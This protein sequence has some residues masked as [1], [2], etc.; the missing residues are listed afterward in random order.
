MTIVKI[1]K[2]NNKG[3][4]ISEDHSMLV[5][6]ALP[7]EI[8][9]VYE[10]KRKKGKKICVAERIIKNS[11]NRTNP[12]EPDHFLSCS[13]LQVFNFALEKKFKKEK[14]FSLL[15]NSNLDFEKKLIRFA[16]NK[17][18]LYNYRN[19][20]EFS[21]YADEED[22]LSLAFFV[23]GS[24]KGKIQ[25]QGCELAYPAINKVANEVLSILNK[26]KIKGRSLKS[27]IVRSNKNGD[28]VASLYVKDEDF[29][30]LKEFKEK[31]NFSF[32]IL[33]SNPLSPSSINSKL[34]FKNG[35]D[36]LFE[37]ISGKIF[38]FGSESFFQINIEMFEKVINDI[39]KHIKKGNLVDLYAGVGTIGIL[40]SNFSNNIKLIE[41]NTE[42]SSF[43]L[44][45]SKGLKN[46]EV[47]NERSEKSLQFINKDTTLILDPPREGLHKDLTTK[48][49]EVQ[50]NQ[51]IYL[52][53][54][55]DSQF[56][57][58]S[59]IIKGYK[60]EFMRIYNFFPK[61]PHIEFLIILNR[62]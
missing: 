38:K 9:K 37:E 46:I 1:S 4:G 22:K 58:I 27:L 15:K 5:W 12:R 2:L 62:K 45:N 13:P 42:A 24:H 53:C 23:R 59:Y 47:I 48:I 36:Y 39:K 55:P 31:L 34:I 18:C 3:Q 29:Q 7:G 20:M 56:K 25:I 32:R 8:L 33:Y 57:D 14:I 43:A 17:D 26:N 30:V 60:I 40:L 16:S 52:S 49:N 61:T 50:P 54:N 41:F 11:P 6:N 28:T 19:K 35:N 51:I 44:E 21:F 10:I